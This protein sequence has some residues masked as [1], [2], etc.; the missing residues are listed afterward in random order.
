MI[1][2]DASLAAKWIFTEDYSEQALSLV[3]NCARARQRVIA[4]PLL[5]IEVTNIIRRRMLSESLTLADAHQFLTRFMAF[6]VSLRSPAT[7]YEQALTIADTHNLPAVY[8]AHYVAL[9]QMVGCTLWTDDRRL[10]TALGGKLTFVKWIGDYV[11][12]EPL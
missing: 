7:L 6:P 10:L 9:A 5:P 11:A 4:P 3:T 1:C 12:G 2:V 8:D